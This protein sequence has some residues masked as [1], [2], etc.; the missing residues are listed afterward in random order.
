MKFRATAYNES[1]LTFSFTF[2][3][4]NWN[5]V[6]EAARKAL[7]EA[8]E[9]DVMHQKYGPWDFRGVDVTA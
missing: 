2:K 4:F 6:A 7:D 8:I 5:G 3:N 1:G 9:A